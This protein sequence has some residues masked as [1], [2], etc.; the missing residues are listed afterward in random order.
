MSRYLPIVVGVLAIVGLTYAQVVMTDRFLTNNVTA[1]REAKKLE[2]VPKEIGD[3]HGEDLKIED[4]VRKKA[5]AVGAV[6]RSYRNVR[7]GEEVNLWL[8]VGHAHDI[9]RHTPNI[10]FPAS[11]FE[12]RANEDSLYPMAFPD[13]PQSPFLTQ[14][15]FKE[16][17]TGRKLVR[18]FWSWYNPE[19]DDNEGKVVWDSPKNARRKFGNARALYK[20][21]FTSEMRDPMETTEQS[22]CIHFARDFLPVVSKVLAPDS[23]EKPAADTATAQEGT[24]SPNAAAPATADAAKTEPATADKNAAPVNAD[25]LTS[26]SDTP[27][28][29]DKG[30]AKLPDTEAPKAAPK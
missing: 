5:G 6:S 23:S 28:D 15:F 12:A 9:W 3:W 2:N 17:F 22:A 16:D 21:Y 11:G 29:A 20:M 14:T 13:Q 19:S 7:T 10:C 27:V 25:L 4:D 30:K 1:E 18:V 24:A 8:I 26:P